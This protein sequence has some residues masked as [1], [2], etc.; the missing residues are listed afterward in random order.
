MSPVVITPKWSSNKIWLN[1]DTREANKAI[2]R[3]HAVMPKLDDIINELNGVT[4]FSHLDVNHVYHKL[5]L[6]ENSHDITTLATHVGLYRNKRANFGTRSK[7]TS[8]WPHW[9]KS[10]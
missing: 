3:T 1:V 6:E 9:S 2:P 4:V 8:V 5:E 10:M 7:L